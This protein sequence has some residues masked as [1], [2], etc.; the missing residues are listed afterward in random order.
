M[1]SIFI[2]MNNVQAL[3]P[4]AMPDV[5][6]QDAGASAIQLDVDMIHQME[7]E[8]LSLYLLKV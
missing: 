5:L 4:Q 1:Y 7:V 2:K 8:L 3:N 6:K